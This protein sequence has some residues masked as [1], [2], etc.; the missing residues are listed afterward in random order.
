MK[1]KAEQKKQFINQLKI[2]CQSISLESLE[3]FQAQIKYLGLKAGFF[4]SSINL[5]VRLKKINVLKSPHVNKK[6]RDQFEIRFYNRLIILSSF[7]H[8]ENFLLALKNLLKEDISF[9]ISL[10]KNV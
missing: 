10:E 4:Y 7:N 9:K 8:N 5:P 3:K 2:R 1:K 6:A